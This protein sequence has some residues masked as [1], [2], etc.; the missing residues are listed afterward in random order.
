M[1]S[2]AHSTS[3]VS[4]DDTLQTTTDIHQTLELVRQAAF[5]G[6]LAIMQLLIEKRADSFVSTHHGETLLHLAASYGHEDFVRELVMSYGADS[7]SINHFN[8]SPLDSAR[9]ALEIAEW[10]T[11]LRHA[12]SIQLLPKLRGIVSF[13][14]NEMK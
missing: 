7:R 12:K 9:Y 8:E 6:D 3:S 10:R 14:E 5:G 1:A 13:L 11:H 2:V 4:T